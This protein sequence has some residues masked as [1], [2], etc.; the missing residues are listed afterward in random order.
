MNI[1]EKKF[2]PSR[3]IE[4]PKIGNS[5]EGYISVAECNGELP[6]EVKRFFW[7]YYTPE[8]IIRGRHAHFNTELILIAVAGII[9]VTTENSQGEKMSFILNHPN[10]GLYIPPDNWHT[11]KYSHN[12]VQLVLASTLYD[13]NDYIRDY[14]QFLSVW[15]K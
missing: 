3:L 9:E 15:K 2:T 7:T 10:Q 1:S 12:A 4:I 13:E 11:M 5:A 14:N 6:F 8:S